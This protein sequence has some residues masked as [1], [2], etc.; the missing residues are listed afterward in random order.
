MAEVTPQPLTPDEEALVRALHRVVYVLPRV[1]DAEMV[2]EQRMS[3]SDYMTLVHL[4][5]A[6]GR[7]MRM[8][9]LADLLAFSL[10][11]T[12]HIVD[13][14]QAQGLV[15]RARSEQDARG[16]N[17]VLTDAGLARLEQAW[18]TNLASVR[19]YAL[20]HLDGIDLRRLARAL[21]HFGT[22]G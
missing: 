11:G 13:R 1:V 9:D 15:D 3:L 8:S 17:A 14:L 18:P 2:R 20:A 4:S 16:W 21:E 5:E 10:S 12:T 22:P 6:P 7:M 19:R